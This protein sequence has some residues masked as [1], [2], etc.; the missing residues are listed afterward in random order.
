MKLERFLY[1]LDAYGADLR[2]WPEAD[3]TPG[4]LL[5]ATSADAARAQREAVRLDSLLRRAAPAISDASVERV[6]GAV[7]H[8]RS[9]EDDGLYATVVASV[10]RRWI[11]PA[12]LGFMAILGFVVGLVDLEG[13][14]ASG[15]TK[16]DL[17][18]AVF[19]TDLAGKLGL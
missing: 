11:P 17:V 16:S 1:L 4:Q 9:P 15:G 14:A 12:L 19:N 10:G 3:R 6:L 18:A 2:R 8:P 7:A 5:L 13:D